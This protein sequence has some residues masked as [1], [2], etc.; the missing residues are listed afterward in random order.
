MAVPRGECCDGGAHML[1]MGDHGDW[2][3][4]QGRHPGVGSR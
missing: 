1:H 2:S 4:G 3:G